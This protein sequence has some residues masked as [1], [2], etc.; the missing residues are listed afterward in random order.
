LLGCLSA[1]RPL[2]NIF[3]SN[4]QKWIREARVYP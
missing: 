3:F 1:V 2:S 4:R